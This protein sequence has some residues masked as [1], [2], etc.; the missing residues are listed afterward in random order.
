MK[1]W[2]RRMLVTLIAGAAICGFTV[3]CDPYYGIFIDRYD[4]DW[5][6]DD[7]PWYVDLGYWGGSYYEE[8]VYHDDWH[9]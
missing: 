2:T 8:V 1:G 3:S 6:C 4:D 9:W 5:C 7:D